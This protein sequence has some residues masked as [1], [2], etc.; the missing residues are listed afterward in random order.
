MKIFDLFTGRKTNCE[1]GH[2]CDCNAGKAAGA[3]VT[4]DGSGIADAAEAAEAK[5]EEAKAAEEKAGD[6]KRVLNLIVVDESGSMEVIREKTISGINETLTT[7]LNMQQE[8]PDLQQM[9]TLVTFDSNHFKVHYQNV[10]V[11][12]T[13][14]LGFHDYTPR[15]LTP[16]YDAI[17][18][19]ISMVREVFAEGDRVLATI[20]TD[21]M[22]NCSREFD[23]KSVKAL[24]E[25]LKN[26][27]WTFALIG[28]DNLDVEGMAHQMSIDDS[29][30]FK[31]DCDG[32]DAMFYRERNARMNYCKSLRSPFFKKDGYFDE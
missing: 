13:A 27:G 7:C 18:K 29:L 30:A 6:A 14:P 20:I 2:E 16:L 4:D 26:E 31:E 12:E 8:I 5:A 17:G 32:T 19:G 23:L 10:P 28:T 11:Q 22:E 21:G 15:G 25:Q 24:I 3:S 9:V 1:T